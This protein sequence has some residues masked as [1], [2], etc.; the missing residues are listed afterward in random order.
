MADGKEVAVRNAA[1]K[2][3]PKCDHP[4]CGETAT[5]K[6]THD[7]MGVLCTYLYCDKHEPRGVDLSYAE[8][9]R[10]D[11]AIIKHFAAFAVGDF[12]VDLPEE[13]PVL[14]LAEVKERYV[15]AVLA[16]AKGN[17]TKTA[18]DLGVDRRTLHRMLKRLDK[19]NKVA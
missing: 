19:A 17:K 6:D 1:L 7:E 8:M 10:P 12:T 4:G 3:L 14:T 13:D 2:D 16:R 18:K 9:V 15:R 11:D 5:K